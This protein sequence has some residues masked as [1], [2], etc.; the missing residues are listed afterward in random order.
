MVAYLWSATWGLRARMERSVQE[1][2]RRIEE[3]QGQNHVGPDVSQVR[4]SA[5]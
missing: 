4:R 3:G 2:Q 5:A 1:L